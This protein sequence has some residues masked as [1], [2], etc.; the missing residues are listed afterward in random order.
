MASVTPAIE[1]KELTAL[2]NELIKISTGKGSEAIVKG[3]LDDALKKSGKFDAADLDIFAKL[4]TLFD[5]G[6]DTVN[7]RDYFCGV[8]GCLLSLKLV[9]RIQFVLATFDADAAGTIS[10]TNLRRAL[11]AIN[12][13]A[14]Y[15]G[16]PV[17]ALTDID[18]VTNET[19][20]AV[21]SSAASKAM[22]IDLTTEAL[23]S[24]PLVQV[25]LAGEGKVR[26]GSS[27]LSPP[28]M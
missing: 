23:L 28:P 6:D 2:R 5:G 16:D 13:V 14:S 20:E 1:Q 7:F 22:P 10:K 27:E 21:T 17:L 19:F 4:F 11:V 15:F 9:E 8:A 25:F 26:F 12:S 3:E 18:Q 24:H